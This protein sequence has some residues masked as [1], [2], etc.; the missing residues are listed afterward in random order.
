MKL[1]RYFFVAV[2][3]TS[4]FSCKKDNANKTCSLSEANL[5][6]T[7]TIGAVMYKASATAQAVDAR[8][9]ADACS[10]DDTETYNADHTIIYTDAGVKCD[11]SDSGTSTWSLSGNTL[12][13]GVGDEGTISA[14]DCSGFTITQ[15]N[16]MVA[17]DSFMVT[18][19]KQ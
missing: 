19:K 5:V 12:K 18:F 6:G 7:Y 4:L 14:F 8:S 17:G 1:S 9:M 13:A 11:P 3:A 2:I 16:F 10:L 15:S